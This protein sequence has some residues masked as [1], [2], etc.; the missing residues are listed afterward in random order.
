MSYALNRKESSSSQSQPISFYQFTVGDQEYLYTSGDI[1]IW[2]LGK[3]YLKSAISHGDVDG[4]SDPDRGTLTL[5]VPYSLPITQQLLVISPS[6]PIDLVIRRAQ[7][8]VYD[9]RDYEGT[10]RTDDAITVSQADQE[11]VGRVH[12]CVIDGDEVTTHCVHI[13]SNQFR[14]GNALRYQKACPYALYEAYNCGIPVGYLRSSP[15]PETL[16]VIS[17]AKVQSAQLQWGAFAESASMDESLKKHWFVGGFVTYFDTFANVEGRR[18]IIEYLPD[19]GRVTVFPPLRGYVEGEYMHFDP[20]CEHNSKCC[21]LKF[22]NIE[23]YGGDPVLPSK[24]P[25]DPFE[26]VF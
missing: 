8:G 10:E 19:T 25:Y 11:W 2:H 18:A 22:Q 24:D 16:S 21:K 1:D 26:K 17:A 14:M 5:T 9:S 3:K 15:A 23:N 13:L 4:T 12:S 6:F 20:G 7:R